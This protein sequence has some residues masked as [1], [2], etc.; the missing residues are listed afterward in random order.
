MHRNRRRHRVDAHAVLGRLDRR[1]AGEC[2]H[3]GLGRSVMRLPLLRAPAQH[4]GVVDHHARFPRIHR[5][6]ER[7]A[8]AENAVE[9][10]VEH[11]EPLVIRHVDHRDFATQA[12][13][14]DQ[15]VDVAERIDRSGVECIDL[16]LPGHVA[17][18]RGGA[19]ADGIGNAIG[20]FT[21]PALVEIADQQGCAFL[22]RAL[23]RRKADA[24]ASRRGDDHGLALEQAARGWIG[25]DG[26]KSPRGSRGRPNPRSAIR[27]RWIWLVPP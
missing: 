21:Q 8:H 22:G 27:L 15:H 2:H 18:A 9:R 4:R 24:G 11:A 26:H 13:V 25:G 19:C 20:R 5:R 16:V 6:Q 10:D 1:T 12:S 17:D 14:V 3:S 23:C 7:A